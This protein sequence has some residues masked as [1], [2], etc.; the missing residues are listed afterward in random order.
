MDNL[1]LFLNFDSGPFW[2]T[3]FW[4]VS[5]KLE[6]IWLY[7]LILWMIY[8]RFGW[9]KTLLALLI[10]VAAVAACDQ[11]ANFFK[12]NYPRLRP[13][14]TPHLEPFLHT[15]R[16]YRG[17]M[18]GTV[19][20]HAATTFSIALISA[21]IIRKKLFTVLIVC[22]SLLVGYSRIYLGVHYPLDVALGLLTGTG[23]GLLGIWAW[24]AITRRASPR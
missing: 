14:R 11:I 19:S 6:W 10:I 21:A 23:V 4:H 17:G 18:Y 24:R 16:G 13:T 3:F 15:V 20:A 2:D 8:R 22:W 7:L 5:G 1:L 9:K 12:A